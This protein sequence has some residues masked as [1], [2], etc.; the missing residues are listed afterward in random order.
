MG[1]RAI[2]WRRPRVSQPHSTAMGLFPTDRDLNRPPEQVELLVTASSLGLKS[3]DVN[4]RLDAFLT[5]H[6]KWRSRSSIQRLIKEG[7]TQV[8]ASR[9]HKPRG[10]GETVEERR[11]GRRLRDGA[12]VVVVIPPDSRLPVPENTS[13]EIEILY[14]DDDAIAVNKPA[15]LP[16]HPSGRHHSDTLIQR[17][18]ARY[19]ESHLERGLAPR[20]CHRLD[21]ET[22]GIVLVAKNPDAHRKLAGQF[23]DRQVEKEYLAIV[24]GI[25][26]QASGQIRLPI[27]PAHISDV[28]LKM[29]VAV[30]GQACRTDWQLVEEHGDCSLLRCQIHTGRQHQIRVHLSAIGHPIVGDKLYGIDEMYFCKQAE[31][32][33]TAEDLQHLLLPRH[34]LHSHRLV[35]RSTV[36]DRP[37]EVI[38]P[39]AP[40]LMEYLSGR[41][42]Y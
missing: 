27:G 12:R 23:E 39:L 35:F 32:T 28:R 19:Q 17:V 24:D 6:L 11:P 30:D 26:E 14:E 41:A 18:H 3:E 4:I 36:T 42:S 5:K 29:T 21:R 34:A 15:M 22:S 25:P 9:P 8:D 33:L 31:G 13:D 10:T 40:D 38:C 1:P 2:P 16:V 37:V 20:L 7:W